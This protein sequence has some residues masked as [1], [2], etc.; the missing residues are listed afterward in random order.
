MRTYHFIEV[1]VFTE[2]IFGGNQLAVFLEPDGLSDVEMQA[3]ARELNLAE[4][5]FVLPSERTEATARVRIFTPMNELPTAGHPTV[6]TTWVLANR[7]R[8]PSGE[9]QVVLEEGIGLVPVQLE[10][11]LRSPSAV[12]MSQRDAEFGP[13][14]SNRPEVAEALGLSAD[15]LLPDQPIMTGSTGMPFLLVP[16]VGPAA[17]DRVEPDMRGIAA[18]CGGTRTAVFVF[19]PD[20]ERGPACVYSRMFAGGPAG[21]TED[22]A[23]G[24]ASGPLG[25]YVVQQRLLDVTDPIEIVSLQGNKMG[26]P[27]HIRIRA[28]RQ[29]ARA[30]QLQIGGGVVPVF[31]GDLSLP[32]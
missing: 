20:G 5:T 30:T 21:V 19:A 2:R 31:E 28:K 4:T 29:N 3:I 15:D 16:L 26:R 13:P 17:V 1:D 22:A 27:S 7:G 6:G 10:G 14:M 18:A 23:T 8:L 32:G 11:D 9:R 12:W 25:A 24:A